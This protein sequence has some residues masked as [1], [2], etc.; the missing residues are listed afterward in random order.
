MY[1]SLKIVRWENVYYLKGLHP[2]ILHTLITK[3]QN[4]DARILV[5]ILTI[6]LPCL[7]PPF[8]LA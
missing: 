2:K 6:I 7:C 4:K 1:Y 3:L 8:I 5:Y